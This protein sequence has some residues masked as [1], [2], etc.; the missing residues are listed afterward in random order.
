MPFAVFSFN[1]H[2]LLF[3]V[4]PLLPLS[5][6]TLSSE[7]NH[8]FGAFFVAIVLFCSSKM[9]TR[10]ILINQTSR[11]IRTIMPRSTFLNGVVKRMSETF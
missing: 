5:T 4:S 8:R 9:A 3:G 6:P 11:L 2:L 7:S 1:Q 10:Q